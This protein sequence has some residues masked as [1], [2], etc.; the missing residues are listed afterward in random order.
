M[1]QPLIPMCLCLGAALGAC[2][3]PEPQ[4]EPSFEQL[5]LGKVQG[6][7]KKGMSS[8]AVVEVLGSPNMV[9]TDDE[10]REVWVYDKVSTERIEATQSN[11]GTLIIL[12]SRASYNK[13]K[14]VQRTLTIIVKF[15]DERKVR[16]YGYNYTQF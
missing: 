15:D 8:A 11:Y 13:S 5:T 4:A 2:R 14:T 6:E 7:I 1:K 12:G 9:T 10:Q 3:L 16:E